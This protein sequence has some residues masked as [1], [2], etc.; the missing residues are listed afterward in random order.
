MQEAVRTYL[1]LALGLTDTSRKKVR[2][3]VKDAVGKGGAT[4]EQIKALTTDLVAANSANRDAMSKLV[5]FEVDRALGVVGL[6]TAEEVSE[7]TA[8]VRELEAQL[9]QARRVAGV[10]AALGRRPTVPAAPPTTV[11]PGRAGSG[12]EDGAGDGGAADGGTGDGGA[13][14]AGAGQAV[15]LRTGW[16]GAARGEEGHAAAVTGAQAGHP[17]QATKGRSAKHRPDEGHRAQGHRV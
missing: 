4:A 5:R 16:A 7:L 2:K 8:R 10:Q 13:G 1:E 6:A 9:V 12:G 17:R 14:D 11:R 15:R 3:A